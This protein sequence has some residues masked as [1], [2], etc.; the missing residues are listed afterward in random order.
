MINLISIKM[1]LKFHYLKN[2]EVLMGSILSGPAPGIITAQSQGK[3]LPS[4]TAP[5]KEARKQTAPL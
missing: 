1:T 2:P 3:V 4:D 5:K